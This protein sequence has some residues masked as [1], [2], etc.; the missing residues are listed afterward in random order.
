MLP[1]D[2]RPTVRAS[3][4]Y[5]CPRRPPGGAHVPLVWLPEQVTLLNLFLL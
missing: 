1:V 2:V 5:P 4:L 3:L